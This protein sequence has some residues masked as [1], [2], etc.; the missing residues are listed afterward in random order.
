MV[1]TYSFISVLIVSLISLVGIFTVAIN[2]KR[3]ES[4]LIY[5][6]SFSAGALFGDAFIHMLLETLSSSYDKKSSA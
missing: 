3:L 4:I 6:I 1:W 5:M 2:E